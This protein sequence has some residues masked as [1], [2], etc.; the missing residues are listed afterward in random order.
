MDIGCHKSMQS[1]MIRIWVLVL[2]LLSLCASGDGAELDSDPRVSV[3]GEWFYFTSGRTKPL[4]G[5]M[6]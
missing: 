5:S 4:D 6:F 3:D 2:T 1:D